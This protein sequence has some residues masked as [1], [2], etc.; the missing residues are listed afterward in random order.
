MINNAVYKV[1]MVK[2]LN[3]I[4]FKMKNKC[5]NLLKR[6][7][8]TTSTF[9]LSTFLDPSTSLFFTNMLYATLQ[10]RVL[11]LLTLPV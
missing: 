2:M 8:L 3:T 9:L 1:E 4:Q 6:I 5:V 7:L 10:A 11:Y